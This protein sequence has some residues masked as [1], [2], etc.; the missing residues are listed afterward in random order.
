MSQWESAVQGLA[1]LAGSFSDL[2]VVEFGSDRSGALLD[3]LVQ[4]HGAKSAIGL[5][6]G[7]QSD[8]E[9]TDGRVQ[10]KALDAANSGLEANSFDRVVSQASFE[11][12]H[13]LPEALVEAHRLLKPGGYLV[14]AFGPIYSGF[15]GHHLWTSVNG[16]LYT[17]MNTALPPWCHL[18]MQPEELASYCRDNLEIPELD[19]SAVVDYVY[20]SD[21]QNRLSFADYVQIVEDSPLTRLAV[22]GTPSFPDASKFAAVSLQETLRRL[23]DTS[24]QDAGY[25]YASMRLLL[26]K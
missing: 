26:Q 9:R 10:L 16:N 24:W 15:N 6:P 7:I 8:F 25:E 13:N 20:S 12:F 3:V 23:A 22:H 14:T 1:D 21:E 5:N 18:Y 17:Y 19:I 11:H 2:D 4:T